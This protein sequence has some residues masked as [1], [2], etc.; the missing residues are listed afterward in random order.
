LCD[1]NNLVGDT[2]RHPAREEVERLD[3]ITGSIDLIGFVPV[4]EHALVERA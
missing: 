3:A 2:R 4:I 1:G